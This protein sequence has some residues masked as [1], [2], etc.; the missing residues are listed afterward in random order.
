M[1]MVRAFAIAA[2]AAL[3]AFSVRAG[4]AT[5]A[6]SALA[7]LYL[8]AEIAERVVV[9]A[10]K[11]AG[12]DATLAAEVGAAARS[13]RARVTGEV[14]ARLLELYPDEDAARKGYGA[15]VERFA[16]TATAEE[17]SAVITRDLAGE[18]AA[19]G[20][21]LGDVQAWLRAKAKGDVPPL[22]AWLARDRAAAAPDAAAPESKPKP[23]RNRNS[24][25]ESE[26]A[27][28]TF[29]EA[30]DDGAG[31]LRSFGAQRKVQREKRLAEAQ[32]G[33]EQVAAER[34]AAD[35]EA[36]ARKLAKAQAEAAAQQAQ[37]Q[38]LAAAEQEAIVQD[39]NSWKTRLKGVL[40]SA[41]GATVGAFTSGIGTQIGTA[42]ADAVLGVRR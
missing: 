1:S 7:A 37:A 38:R 24:L 41:V 17:R 35:E 34:K 3:S 18:V 31:S 40:S 16:R 19:A 39:Q 11:L 32:Q 29:V 26:A 4:D 42:A 22:A 5:V 33:M 23:R 14:R 30:K 27:A 2:I 8:K 10:A 25:R 20:N 21:F 15:F 6:D 13:Y 12:E 28:G 9:E 36:N